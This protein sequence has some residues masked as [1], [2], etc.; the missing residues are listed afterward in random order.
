M[1][2]KEKFVLVLDSSQLDTFD[3]CPQMWHYQYEERLIPN[4]AKPNTPMDMGT[5]GHKLFEILYKAEAAGSSRLDAVE[6]ASKFDIDHEV[7]RCSHNLERHLDTGYEP[8]IGEGLITP[9]QTV[10]CTCQN[11]DPVQFP[12]SPDERKQVLDR[13]WEYAQFEGMAIP[14][15]RAKSPDHVETG[16]SKK[17]YEDDERLYILEG[18]IDFLGQIAGNVPEG[19]ADHKWQM[20]AR[21][22]YLKPIQFRNYSLATELTIGVVNYVR[23][24]KK[25]DPKETVKRAIIS[26]SRQEMQWWA[27]QLPKRFMQVEN[28]IKA[29]VFLMGQD[30]EKGQQW[31]LPSDELRRRSAC[32]G[33]FDYPCGFV[34][35]CENAFN[36][37][38]VQIMQETD[39]KQ[40]PIWR[41]W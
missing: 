20:R 29:P 36:P 5:Y 25:F 18:R 12:L 33:K 35:L 4:T 39:F 19:W 30:L 21:D 13:F 11:F 10:G 9:C 15:L 28:A 17:I 7:C 26:F 41:P 40:R 34:S 14:L 2:L 38:F 22:L 27:D 24:M 3:Q 1:S 32:S 16:F 8:L 6:K 23:M 31:K 37:A